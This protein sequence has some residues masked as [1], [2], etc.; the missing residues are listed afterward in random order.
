MRLW[1]VRPN[2]LDTKG[3]VALWR[4]GLLAKAVLEGKTRGYRNHPQLIRFRNHDQPVIAI[5]EYLRIVHAE[6][7]DR[8]YRFDGSKIP[9]KPV[10]VTPIEETRGQ[11]NYE[12]RHLLRK[13]EDRD[14]ERYSR[15]VSRA[16]GPASHPLFNIV[17]GEIREWESVAIA[18]EAT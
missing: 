14:P 12:W 11:L 6:S 10:P 2:F 17:E 16:T 8:G 15:L 4:E 7:K 13:L 18:N 5:C 1:T 9:A 3:L